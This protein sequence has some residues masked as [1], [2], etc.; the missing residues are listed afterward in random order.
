MRG[1]QDAYAS[2]CSHE[3][4]QVSEPKYITMRAQEFLCED[5]HEDQ[6]HDALVTLITT[7]HAMGIPEVKSPKLLKSLEDRN[8]FMDTDWLW[9]HAQQIP[10]VDVQSSSP[11]LIKLKLPKKNSM[12]P[13]T[14]PEPA[15]VDP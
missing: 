12:E 2:W 6:A 9:A 8:F 5:T 13:D 14:A 4:R 1:R 10:V 15:P 3:C 7:Q 11:D